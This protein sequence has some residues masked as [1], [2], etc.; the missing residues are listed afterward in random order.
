MNNKSSRRLSAVG[1]AYGR[2][3][4][5]CLHYYDAWIKGRYGNDLWG[6]REAGESTADD[7]LAVSV[8]S[9]STEEDKAKPSASHHQR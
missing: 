6:W 4:V 1:L 9:T 5:D 8:D 3:A 7:P 2:L